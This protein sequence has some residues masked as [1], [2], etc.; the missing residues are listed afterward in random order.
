MNALQTGSCSGTEKLLSTVG[1][2][3]EFNI[4]LS[5]Q[6]TMNICFNHSIQSLSLSKNINGSDSRAVLLEC[7]NIKFLVTLMI[8]EL[9]LLT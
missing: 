3:V 6:G 7:S 5:H 1:Q 8:Q 9:P 2:S 4:A